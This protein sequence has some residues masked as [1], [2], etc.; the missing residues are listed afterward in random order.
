MSLIKRD[1]GGL[2]A[3]INEKSDICSDI[4][5]RVYVSMFLSGSKIIRSPRSEFAV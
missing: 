2:I 1:H 3:S 4:L 5:E